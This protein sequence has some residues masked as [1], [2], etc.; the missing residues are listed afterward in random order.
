LIQ[1]KLAE[2]ASKNA[3][4]SKCANN[5]F[6]GRMVAILQENPK[7][8]EFVNSLGG[9]RDTAKEHLKKIAGKLYLNKTND[10]FSFQCE[11]WKN[12]VQQS[13]EELPVEMKQMLMPS[14]QAGCAEYYA[15]YAIHYLTCLKL[16]NRDK[17]GGRS[18]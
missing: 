14:D 18:R 4:S 13:C 16:N 1:S 2:K 15:D 7:P 5:H 10:T 3:G 17:A 8:G 12:D 6:I 9:L 11:D